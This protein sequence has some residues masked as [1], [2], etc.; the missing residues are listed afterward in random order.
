MNLRMDEPTELL[1]LREVVPKDTKM[2]LKNLNTLDEAW[3][4]LDGEFGDQDRLTAERVRYLHAFHCS[5]KMDIARFKQRHQVWRE[6]YTDLDKIKAVQNLD[7]A[8][9]LET[10]V[11]NFPVEI[12]KGSIKH[13]SEADMRTSKG[14]EVINL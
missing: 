8:L 3:V 6:V 13:V 4:F 2:E 5:V 12:R 9:T 7:S 11:G 14:S 1:K 10:Y